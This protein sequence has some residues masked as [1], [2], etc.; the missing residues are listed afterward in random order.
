MAKQFK[1]QEFQAS[2]SDQQGLLR[3]R[4]PTPMLKALKAGHGDLIHYTMTGPDTVEVKVL[5]KRGFSGEKPYMTRETEKPAAKKPAKA[6]T[7]S[8]KD[9]GSGKKT[10][11]ISKPSAGKKSKTK[12][13]VAYSVPGF[14]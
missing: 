4:V 13:K 3:S 5:R 8:S 1:E 9:N 12:K 11:P 14:D 7:A 2:V 10:G 6:A